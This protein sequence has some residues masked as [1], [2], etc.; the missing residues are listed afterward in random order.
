MLRTH[1]KH[2][3]FTSFESA[4]SINCLQSLRLS[5]AAAGGPGGGFGQHK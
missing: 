1:P 2:V 4:L 5:W 3:A